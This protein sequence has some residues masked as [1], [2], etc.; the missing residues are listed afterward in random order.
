MF[1]LLA[2]GSN[3]L[4]N[5]RNNS[6]NEICKTDTYTYNKP[7]FG[8]IRFLNWQKIMNLYV[9]SDKAG[10]FTLQYL[11]LQLDCLQIH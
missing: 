9:S 3:N 4:P 11:H 6:T 5:T 10:V 8:K 1:N 7:S 2:K